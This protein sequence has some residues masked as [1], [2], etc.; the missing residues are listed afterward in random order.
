MRRVRSKGGERELG[1]GKVKIM[2][3]EGDTE[4]RGVDEGR[5]GLQP[6]DDG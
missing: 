3:E 2:K 4:S 1:R 6:G 5:R